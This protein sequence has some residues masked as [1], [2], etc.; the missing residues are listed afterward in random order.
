MS[1][2]GYT[3]YRS[4]NPYAQQDDRAQGGYGQQQGGYGQQAGGYG[5]QQGGQGGYGQQSGG[6]PPQQGQA[7]E[8]NPVAN[9]N[10]DALLRDVQEM[11]DELSE[12]ERRALPS[13]ES[14]HQ[15]YFSA[16]DE[17][18]A[19]EVQRTIDTQ[20]ANISATN[21]VIVDRL[22]RMKGKYGQNNA[23]VQR[24]SNKVE[25]ILHQYRS[26]ENNFSKRVREQLER[27][28]RVVNRNAT[29]EEVQEFLA[30]GESQVFSQAVLNNNRSAQANS[31]LANVRNR[32]QEIQRIEQTLTELAQMFVQMNESIVEQEVKVEAIDNYAENVRTDIDNGVQ[33]V[34]VAKESARAARRKKWWCLLISIIILVVIVVAV[35]VGVVVSRNASGT[36]NKRRRS[37]EYASANLVKRTAESAAENAIESMVVRRRNFVA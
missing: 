26:M 6:Y 16:I 5:Q 1:G 30:T 27:Q 28:Y 3:D 32:H 11:N 36:A 14:L 31:A 13:L 24:V 22:R 25:K 18:A 23:Q 33:Q 2:R 12:L 29:E 19:G 20:T 7:Y 35:V 8:M 4:D 15:R 9:D 34:E 37:L 17:A 21:R 10:E